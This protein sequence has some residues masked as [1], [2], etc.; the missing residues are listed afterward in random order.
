MA[1]VLDDVGQRTKVSD[2]QYDAIKI[3]LD[4]REGRPLLITTNLS[5]FDLATV[6]DER[7]SSRLMGGTVIETSG[8]RRIEGR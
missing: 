4:R 6:Y 7:I 5:L 3:A 2:C 1:C 8:D